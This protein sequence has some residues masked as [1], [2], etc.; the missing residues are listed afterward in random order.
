MLQQHRNDAIKKRDFVPCFSIPRIL[1]AVYEQIAWG[2]L[3]LT[4]HRFPLCSFRIFGKNSKWLSNSKSDKIAIVQVQTHEPDL[5]SHFTSHDIQPL[6]L[7]FRWLMRGFSGH[8]PPEQVCFFFIL[9]APQVFFNLGGFLG[10]IAAALLVGFSLGL[11]F[12]GSL[13]PLSRGHLELQKGQFNGSGHLCQH[14]SSTEW[15]QLFTRRS[16]SAI[17]FGT[18]ADF[19]FEPEII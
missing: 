19:T 17:G 15:P 11:W 8:L 10:S 18:L 13:S 16:T 3:W 2:Q 14:R 1:Y 5:W 9:D 12:Y 4:R 7:V 6:R